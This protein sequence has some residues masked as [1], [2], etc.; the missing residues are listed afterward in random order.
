MNLDC[1]GPSRSRRENGR[2]KRSNEFGTS[3]CLHSPSLRKARECARAHPSLPEAATVDVQLLTVAVDC[4]GGPL[5]RAP[6]F[7]ISVESD[8]LKSTTKLTSF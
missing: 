2:L 8:Q 3:L 7:Y 1:S 5:A 6:N 4:T